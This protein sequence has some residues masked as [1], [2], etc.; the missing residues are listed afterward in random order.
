MQ[1]QKQVCFSHSLTTVAVACLVL[2]SVNI[3]AATSQAQQQQE[4][5]RHD[6]LVRQQAQMQQ[7]LADARQRQAQ[8]QAAT[9][10]QEAQRHDALVRQQAQMQQQLADARQRQAQQA[11]TQYVPPKQT[12]Q[13]PYNAKIGPATQPSYPIQYDYRGAY[14]TVPTQNQNPTS[15]HG[16]LSTNQQIVGKEVRVGSD[17]ANPVDATRAAIN[18]ANTHRADVFMNG[19]SMLLGVGEGRAIASGIRVGIGEAA[20]KT[21][22]NETISNINIL[23]TTLHGSERIAGAN[24]TRGGVLSEASAINVMQNGQRLTQGNGLLVR[25]IQNQNGTFN[26]VVHK[27]S[28]ELVTTFENLSQ[29]SISRLAKNYGWK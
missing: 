24:A 20:E 2:V 16:S 23:K 9:Q 18:Y 8:Q 19:A 6:A 22:A 15:G 14:I 12:S 17:L 11:Q 3:F 29:N 27:P 4:A 5:Q 10:Q 13:D 26:A 28:G 25:M 7:Q 1:S 21:V